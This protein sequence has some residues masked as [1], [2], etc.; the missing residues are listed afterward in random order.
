MLIFLF[1]FR[2]KRIAVWVKRN[3][4]SVLFTQVYIE[5]LS[6]SWLQI[7]PH[8]LLFNSFHGSSIIIFW[9]RFFFSSLNWTE[10]KRL[11]IYLVS[12]LFLWNLIWSSMW[13]KILTKNFLLERF[14]QANNEIIMN[15]IYFDYFH[16]RIEFNF[17]TLFIYIIYLFSFFIKTNKNLFKIQQFQYL[18]FQNVFSQWHRLRVLQA[19]IRSNSKQ[20]KNN[21]TKHTRKFNTRVRYCDILCSRFFFAKIWIA[22]NFPFCIHLKRKVLTHSRH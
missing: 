4:W 6:A 21:N 10:L 11:F 12:L 19:R 18:H 1:H 5:C 7:H 8:L 16:C 20:K 9:N 17:V 13:N 3:H 2:L 15:V 22:M 14:A